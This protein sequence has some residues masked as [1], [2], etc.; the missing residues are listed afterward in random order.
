MKTIKPSYMAVAEV[1]I[2]ASGYT[3]E[4]LS[5]PRRNREMVIVRQVVFYYLRTKKLCS[6]AAAGELFNRDH[7]TV[8]HA[9]RTVTNLIDTNY[10]GSKNIIENLISIA[11]AYLNCDMPAVPRDRASSQAAARW[12]HRNQLGNYCMPP[13]PRRS[14]YAA[15]NGYYPKARAPWL[16]K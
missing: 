3:R 8:I 7:A 14:G 2:A 16:P 13:M 12:P 1:M 15:A 6:F 11:D 10:A 5:H 9:V 4:E